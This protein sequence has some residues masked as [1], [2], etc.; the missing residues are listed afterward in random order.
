[1]KKLVF[2]LCS[3]VVL[4]IVFSTSA[5]ASTKFPDVSRTYWAYH[6]INFLT[7]KQVIMGYA[8]G[9]FKPNEI[10]TRKDAASLLVRALKKTNTTQR[11]AVP[12]D[13]VPT[14]SGY[15]EVIASVN[16]DLFTVTNNE[17]KPYDPLT[18]KEMA[19]A[20]A[21]AFDYV[22]LKRTSF[23]DV[24]KSN[25]YYPFIDGIAEF[26]VTTGYTDGTFRPEEL[27]TRAQFSAFLSRI[28]QEP[29]EYTVEEN[30]QVLHTVRKPD[31]AIN[32][33]LNYD[34]A[35][36]HPVDN[37]LV[38]FS[39]EVSSASKTDLSKGVLIYNGDER[40]QAFSTD[41]Y[42]PYLVKDIQ[43][44]TGTMF[45]TFIFL[46]RKASKEVEFTELPNNTANY[47]DWLS[48][49]NKTFDEKGGLYTLNEAAKQ[50]N[51]TVNV[52]LSIPYPKRQGDIVGF[53]GVAMPNTTEERQ[54]LVSWYIQNVEMEWDLA[55]YSNLVFKGYYWLNETVSNPQD[56]ILIENVANEIHSIGK[57]FIYSPHATSNNFPLWQTLGFD[58]AFLQP[59]AFKMTGSGVKYRIHLAFLKA[60]IYGNSIN[61]EI[62]SH[63]PNQILEGLANFE[64][65]IDLAKRY[66]LPNH[67]FIMYQDIEMVYR[68]ANATQPGFKETYELLQSIMN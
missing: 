5:S 1:M 31:E 18:R 47:D 7:D 65:Y 36:V 34:K 58:D 66:N 53:D 23:K 19:K 26:K 60:Q 14:M 35:T 9:K 45:D 11:V 24:S 59:N 57:Y 51:Q 44:N 49:V 55:Q 37:G 56:E 39:R 3:F 30:G 33:A 63:G 15:D 52:Y 12:T 46:G 20:L 6:D 54:K 21:T 43:N 61:V 64:Q 13:L 2:Y 25:S 62:N 4:S 32:L 38:S 41:Y 40:K 68:M 42:K 8:D 50:V 22:G 16:L 27:V 48:Y 10:L 28:Y 67:R 29:L 17:F